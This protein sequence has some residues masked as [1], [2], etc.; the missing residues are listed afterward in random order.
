MSKIWALTLRQTFVEHVQPFH[1]HMFVN[2]FYTANDGID[3]PCFIALLQRNFIFTVARIATVI[4]KVIFRSCCFWAVIIVQFLYFL[5]GC[6]HISTLMRLRPLSDFISD[7]LYLGCNYRFISVWLLIYMYSNHAYIP[8]YWSVIMFINVLL[9]L[10]C[11][12]DYICLAIA[13]LYPLLNICITC[14]AWDPYIKDEI[15]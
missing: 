8:S 13:G 11:N 7:L 4:A 2:T 9:L 3:K 15:D 10:D 5:L 6:I 1:S 14:S 12:H